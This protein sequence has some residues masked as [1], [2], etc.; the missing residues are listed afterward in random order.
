M[1]CASQNPVQNSRARSSRSH[2]PAHPGLLR[3]LRE[4][5]RGSERDAE[6]LLVAEQS[7][8][9]MRNVSTSAGVGT[10]TVSTGHRV[11]PA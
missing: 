1:P 6:V 8:P 2:R 3:L 9:P 4:R 11:P 7:G 5:P 10:E